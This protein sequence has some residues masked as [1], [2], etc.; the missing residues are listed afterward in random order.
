MILELP[1][2]WPIS[3]DDPETPPDDSQST[4]MILDSP[5]DGRLAGM[6]LE[7]RRAI[8]DQPVE[9]LKLERAR[10]RTQYAIAQ[11]YC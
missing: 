7:L 2:G 1:G 5:A 10:H 3:G 8:A 11:G 4:G 6:I 9:L